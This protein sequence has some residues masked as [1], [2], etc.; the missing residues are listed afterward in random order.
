M[1]QGVQHRVLLVNVESA[2]QPAV[3]EA[4]RSRSAEPANNH[5][6]VGSAW[7]DAL[8]HP[9][10]AHLFIVQLA[11]GADPAGVGKLTASLPGQPVLV[12]LAGADLPR[13]LAVQRA[14][15]AQ[16]VPLPWQPDDFLHAL[17]C[18][19]V[20]FAPPTREAKVIAVS[21]VSGGSGATTLALN[22]AFELLHA[23]GGPARRTVLLVE[24]ARQM[25]TLATYLNV[26]PPL[27]VHELLIDPGR[28][29][30]HGVRAALTTVAPGLDVLA[31]PYLDI[32]P[33]AVSPR[34]VYQLIELCRRM[35][36][37]VVLDVP[38]AYDDLQFETLALADQVVLVGVQTVSS[39]RTLKMVR[40]TLE[41]EEGIRNTQVVVNRY[42][43]TMVG[44]SA[45]RLADLL[46]VPSVHTITN[47][48]P[49]VMS[50][51]NHGKPLQAAAPHS[52]VL[53]DIRA[54]ARSLFGVRPSASS[55]QGDR[56]ARALGRGVPAPAAPR[57]IRVLHV[58]DDKV[59]REAMGLHLAAIRVFN[60]TVRSASSEEGAVEEFT[61]APADVVLLDFH[62]EEGNGL[63][64]LRRLRALDPIVPIIVVSGLAESRVAAELLEA[65]ADDFLSK[66]NLSAERLAGSLSDAVVRA[67]ACKHRNVGE[68]GVEAILDRVQR[69]L[70]GGA[71]SELL[72][73]LRELHDAGAGRFG[74]AQ[75]Q[76][77][78]DQVCAEL[79]K[80]SKGKELPRRAMLTLFLRLFGTGDLPA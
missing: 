69:A 43:P 39:V 46:K 24:L 34:H 15:A 18:L 1:A 56:L 7:A 22:L 73:S 79:G 29:T 57:A 47:D 71:D 54:L 27:T 17:D 2:L 3:R 45:T 78:V 41:R 44:F 51:L 20:Q 5:P 80:S 11:V 72:R 55:D 25:G 8:A 4:L 33:G 14:G 13:L 74:A 6:D 61:R 50:A 60:C 59:Q 65:G 23:P 40:E 30:T 10:D 58:E 48:Y 67:D 12:L 75:V 76:R 9:G 36:S 53:A 70:P 26:E 31:G 42:E 49:S 66:E 19:A 63:A 52:R 62:L 68:P 64:C 32:T 77:M 28:L 35:A 21:G 37:T 38:C 16:V